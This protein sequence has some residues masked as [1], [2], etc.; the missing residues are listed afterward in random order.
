MTD[1]KRAIINYHAI[2][3]CATC[4]STAEVRTARFN[5]DFQK[6]VESCKELG[7]QGNLSIAPWH[8]KEDYETGMHRR[9]GGL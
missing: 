6:E 8:L 1:P 7:H 2:F 4:G 9:R 5:S 3:E